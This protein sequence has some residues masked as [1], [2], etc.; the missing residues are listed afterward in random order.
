MKPLHETQWTARERH[1]RHRHRRAR[2]QA[3]HTLTAV[4]RGLGAGEADDWLQD[5]HD[6]ANAPQRAGKRGK[7]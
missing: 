5:T 6:D 2:K 7:A 4:L 1:R 3:D